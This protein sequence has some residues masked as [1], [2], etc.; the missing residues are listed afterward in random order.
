MTS[1]IRNLSNLNQKLEEL[2]NVRE[3]LKNLF[4]LSENEGRV[5]MILLM[6]DKLT[7]TKISKI[8]DIQRTHIYD[9]SRRLKEKGLI[10][11]SGENPQQFSALSPRI[12]TDNWLFKSKK[13]L[14]EKSSQLLSF[15][16]T[17]QKVWTD[18][19]EE[20]LSSR[21]SLISE[22]YIREII[23][24]EI[25]LAQKNIFLALRDPPSENPQMSGSFTRLFDPSAF[26][27]D[28]LNFLERGV[29]LKIL[30]GNP[31][32]FLN[33]SHPLKLKALVSGFID[34]TIEVRALNEPFPQSFLLVDN[35]RVYLFFLSNYREINNE[36]I[37][38]ESQSLRQFFSM[39]WKRLWEDATPL[40][41]EIILN[42][43][44]KNRNLG[45]NHS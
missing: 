22:D 5:Y 11:I 6:N 28:I 1:E 25:K 26:Q 34:G 20:H 37:R 13:L 31:D 12:A 30:I 3:K 15:L 23:P 35:E 16:P 19:H 40:N 2:E 45:E 7:A 10:N 8:S 33:R 36:A 38:A 4:D 17:L 9:I 27:S 29:Q 14:E 24:Q 42:A 41:P 39:I 32:L 21:I 18:Q 43:S 44:A